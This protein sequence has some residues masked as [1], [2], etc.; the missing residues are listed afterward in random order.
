[1]TAI[2]DP[3]PRM[4][5]RALKLFEKHN[6]KKPKVY[7]KGDYDYRNLLKQ[8]DIDAVI[9][10]SPWEWHE[11]QAIES[12]H[13]GKIVGL[14]VCGA[15]NLQECWNYVDAYEKTKVPIFMMENVCYRR[16]IMAVFNMI[17]KGKFGEILHGQGGYQ[18]D[19]RPVLFND[20]VQTL[21]RWR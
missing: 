21:W 17:R 19:L 18:H 15:M 8:K 14:E 3:E 13:A 5:E 11:I 9:I 10:S 16:D 7:G 1:M 4:V 12:M 6:K 2:A 20:G